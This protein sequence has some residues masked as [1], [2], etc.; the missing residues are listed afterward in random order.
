MAVHASRH[1]DCE[2]RRAYERA[3]TYQLTQATTS[4]TAGVP[5]VVITMGERVHDWSDDRAYYCPSRDCPC[6]ST[7]V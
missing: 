3:L 2:H 5:L 1:D 7:S 4:T 6:H